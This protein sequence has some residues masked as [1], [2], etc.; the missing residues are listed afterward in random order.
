MSLI[1]YSYSIAHVLGK[2]LW[3]ADTLSH[4]LVKWNVAPDEN[5]L[6]EGT[7][8]YVDMVMGNLAVGAMYL[9]QLKQELHE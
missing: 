7:I 4:A 6:L 9:D 5:K 2:C 8:I 1:R 3:T